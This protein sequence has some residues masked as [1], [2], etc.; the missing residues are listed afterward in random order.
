MKPTRTAARRLRKPDDQPHPTLIQPPSR[1]PA[2]LLQLSSRPPGVPEKE[3]DE[4]Q[5]LVRDTAEAE[6]LMRDMRAMLEAAKQG[7]LRKLEAHGQQILE[8]ALARLAAAKP[9]SRMVQ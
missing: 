4:Y 2:E 6:R 1:E 7:I 8:E 5:R 3:W 9:A